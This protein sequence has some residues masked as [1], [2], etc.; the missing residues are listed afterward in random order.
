MTKP[1]S[2][3]EIKA[4]KAEANVKRNKKRDF[5]KFANQM[6]KNPTDHLPMISHGIGIGKSAYCYYC[7][8]IS[9]KVTIKADKTLICRTCQ[10]TNVEMRNKNASILEKLKWK[11]KEFI[12]AARQHKK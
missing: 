2:K 5:R 6:F 9:P 12:Y 4:R 3:A 11:Y 7:R 10:G 1:L 8:C